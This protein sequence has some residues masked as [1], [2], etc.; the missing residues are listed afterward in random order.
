MWYYFSKGLYR[1]HFSIW[2]EGV[3]FFASITLDIETDI[4][5]LEISIVEKSVHCVWPSQNSLQSMWKDVQGRYWGAV[6][7][8]MSSHIWVAGPNT[9]TQLNVDKLSAKQHSS[10]DLK[11]YSQWHINNISVRV[12]QKYRSAKTFWHRFFLFFTSLWLMSY[13]ISTIELLS[14]VGARCRAALSGRRQ[15]L[16]SGKINGSGENTSEEKRFEFCIVASH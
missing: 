14:A 15:M 9:L 13:R 16:T 11:K 6:Q 3:V 7:Q 5:V 12:C 10:R 4:W 2:N 1:V 8:R